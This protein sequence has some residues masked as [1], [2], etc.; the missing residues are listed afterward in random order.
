MLKALAMA[1]RTHEI[2]EILGDGI[3]AELSAAVHRVAEVLPA[4]LQFHPIELSRPNRD[5]LGESL[6]VEAEAAIRRYHTALK[7]PT[8]T[9]RESPNAVLR[10]RLHFSVIH[11]P[12]ASIPGI[13]T[14]FTRP[15]DLHIVRVATGGTYDDAGR[16]VGP[17]AAV[18]IRVIERRPC[19]EAA[20]FALGLANQLRSGVVS[21]SKYT[22]QRAADGLFEEAVEAVARRYPGVPHRKEL[23]DALLARLVMRPDDYRVIVTPNEYG[24]FLSDLACGLI[25]SMGLGDSAS[26]SFTPSGEVENALF[27]PAG[28]TAPDIAGRDLANPTAALF[29]MS[30]MLRHLHEDKAGVALKRATLDAIGAGERTKDL[31]GKLG[32][33]AFTDAVIQRFTSLLASEAPLASVPPTGA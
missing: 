18:S 19:T 9:V 14:L 25:G 7:Y 29:A 28:G 13:P 26:Y 12:V 23:F 27:D 2:V 6:Y 30:S 8:E 11:R 5:K 32:T 31:G 15:I 21:T 1:E 16:R 4:K 3:S 22:I 24:D 17:D 10:E 20:W 33:M